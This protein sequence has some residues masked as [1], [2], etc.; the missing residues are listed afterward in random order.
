V[1]VRYGFTCVGMC[2]CVNGLHHKTLE[3]F[4]SWFYFVQSFSVPFH[5]MFHNQ[6]LTHLHGMKMRKACVLDIVVELFYILLC[7][8]LSWYA[9]R[10][11][12]V[13]SVY[14]FYIYLIILIKLISLC[15]VLYMWYFWPVIIWP[16]LLVTCN[17]Y[18]IRSVNMWHVQCQKVS[19]EI[20]NDY[21]YGIV[22]ARV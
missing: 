12:G 18:I 8:V 1:L 7:K 20:C 17:I 5:I 19:V 4:K 22:I 3:N 13:C 9:G 14:L 11:C 6:S 10:M 2:F 15:G 21:W 16:V